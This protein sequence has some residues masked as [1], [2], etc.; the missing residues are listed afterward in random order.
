MNCFM[1]FQPKKSETNEQR[2]KK[3]EG[4]EKQIDNDR[5]ERE[6]IERQIMG[7]RRERGR[8]LEHENLKKLLVF[9]K[10]ILE[11]INK[12]CGILCNSV[13]FF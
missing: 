13:N 8:G 10:D 12:L 3:E 2:L 9:I 6:T 4:K 7:E 1:L 5:V 11:Q